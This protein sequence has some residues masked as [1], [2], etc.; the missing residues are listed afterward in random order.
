MYIN[1]I[2]LINLKV[3]NYLVHRYYKEVLICFIKNNDNKKVRNKYLHFYFILLRSV[4]II[5]TN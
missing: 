5:I 1:S 3:Y 4:I 2:M